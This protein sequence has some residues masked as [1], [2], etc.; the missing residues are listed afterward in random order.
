M[1]AGGGS[2]LTL[3][4][5]ILMGYPPV[6]ANGTNRL[7]VLGQS[8]SSVLTFRRKGFYGLRTAVFL[9]VPA[10]IGAVAG[11]LA[12]LHVSAGQFRVLLSTV[13]LVA[14]ATLFVPRRRGSVEDRLSPRAMPL[15]FAI[16]VLIGFYGGFIQAGV[17][18]L[19]MAALSGLGRLGLARTNSIKVLVVGAYT[20][21][22]LAIFVANGSI[23][24][25]PALVLTAGNALGGWVGTLF[26]V[27]KG[28]GRIRAILAMAV[29]AMALKL[30]GV[31]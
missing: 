19:I 7:A 18:F 30:A 12:A 22:S 15:Q 13:M 23:A 21:P 29:A 8:A 6:V 28:E 2:L 17:G 20:L 3:P 31:F 27:A 25:L 4:A 11:T 1:V 14:A 10:C 16:F 5:L 9:S 26:S 24:W